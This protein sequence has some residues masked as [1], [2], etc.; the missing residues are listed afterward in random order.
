MRWLIGS[1]FLAIKKLYGDCMKDRLFKTMSISMMIRH[2]LY[3]L[4]REQILV[5]TDSRRGSGECLMSQSRRMGAFI[6]HSSN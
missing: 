3:N 2:T 4:C 6:T 1:F 5:R